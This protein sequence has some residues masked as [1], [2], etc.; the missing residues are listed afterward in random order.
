MECEVPMNN[1]PDTEIKSILENSRNIAVVGLST[2]PEKDSHRVGVYLK[3]NGY[4]VIP[5][6]PKSDEII[7][8]KAFP[9][10][11][12]IP[13]PVDVVCL[14]RPPEHVPPFVNDAIDIKAKVVWMQ[15]G[16]VNNES[17]AKAAKAGL[18]VVM[19]KCMKIEH[20]KFIG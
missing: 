5:V 18:Q 2:N 10:L 15:L 4:N 8:K 17:G 19:N 12:D 3:E 9:S 1:A 6:H 14:F 13:E 7:G 16:I 11:K 20:A